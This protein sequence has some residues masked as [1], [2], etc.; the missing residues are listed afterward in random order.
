MERQRTEGALFGILASSWNFFD[1]ATLID[2][3]ESHDVV[4]REPV[5]LKAMPCRSGPRPT[6]TEITTAT[7]PTT[8]AIAMP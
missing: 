5:V 4:V 1:D 7:V 6:I 2:V 3:D 8:I